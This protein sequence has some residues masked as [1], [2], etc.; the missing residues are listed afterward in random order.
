MMTRSGLA[1]MTLAMFVSP[2]SERHPE[3]AKLWRVT[4][5]P[6]DAS[7]WAATR[8]GYGGMKGGALTIPEALYPKE[9][10]SPLTAMVSGSWC[11]SFAIVLGNCWSARTGTGPGHFDGACV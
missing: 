3:T 6:A 1:A 10:L 11:L 2:F 7:S 5:E 9:M 4:F 8:L